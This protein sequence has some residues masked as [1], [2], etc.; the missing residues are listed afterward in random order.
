MFWLLIHF[1][2][3]WLYRFSY[4][5]SSAIDYLLG[6]LTILLAIDYLL[7]NWLSPGYLTIFLAIDYVLA[8]DSLLEDLYLSEDNLLIF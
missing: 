3:I 1:V 5:H 8:F 7:G 6:Y 4:W 2:A